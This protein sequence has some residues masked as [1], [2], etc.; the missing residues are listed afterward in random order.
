MGLLVA[1]A[2]CSGGGSGAGSGTGT[3]GGTGRVPSPRGGRRVIVIGAGV[4]GLAAARD[5]S[6]SGHEVIVLEARD[7]LGGRVWT[8]RSFGIPIEMGAN[9]IEGA[10]DNPVRAIADEAGLAHTP[11][12]FDDVALYDHRGRPVS[13]ADARELDRDRD[14]LVAEVEAL[15]ETLDEDI[16]VRAAIDR[17]L[18]G[19]RPD[20]DE[21]RAL[22]WI[23]SIL[24]TATAEDLDR[25]S[26]L[27]FEEDESYAG[28]DHLVVPG[29]DGVPAFLARGLDIRL[30]Q[31]VTRIAHDERGVEV[32]TAGS[33]LT[34]DRAVVTLPL[35]VLKAGTVEFSPA[36]PAAKQEAI[37]RLGFGVLDKIVMEFPSAFWPPDRHFVSCIT[38]EPN[39][40]PTFLD[41][42]RVHQK[43]V[44][45]GF[46]GGSAARRL[47]PMDD[48]A[49]A[50]LAMST[51]R[52]VW[53]KAPTPSRVRV[54]RWGADRFALGS[55]SHIVVDGTADDHDR[56]AEPVAGRLFFAGEATHR[57]FP[58]TVH[59]ALLSGIRAAEA[60]AAA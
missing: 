28:E 12:D 35:G 25:L 55:Y 16:S 41:L 21:T 31:I 19:E 8:D 47:Y 39:D 58:G 22:R 44:L 38:G 18:A 36:L 59:G 32:V 3:G 2:G 33:T 60:V 57:R 37:R 23:E 54:T 40:P 26:L 49:A 10:D 53:P 27:A 34:A 56:L 29:Y 24:L 20:A 14:E 46:I 50:A 30:D 51:L 15:S 1:L 9:W 6:R 11:S 13:A 52:R 17:V 45:V 43:P 4:A 42:R 48:A 7:R 5:L